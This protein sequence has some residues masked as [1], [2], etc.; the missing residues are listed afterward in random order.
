M[1]EKMEKMEKDMANKMEK[2]EKD[3]AG[4]MEKMVK[5][6]AE[7]EGVQERLGLVG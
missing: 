6:M 2:T 7:V 5:D 3:M 1:V 4:R